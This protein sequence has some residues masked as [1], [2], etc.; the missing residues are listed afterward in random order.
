MSSF[1]TL[2]DIPGLLARDL[3]VTT[4]LQSE[5]ICAR[6]PLVATNLEV[7]ASGVTAMMGARG[8]EGARGMGEAMVRAWKMFRAAFDDDD[9]NVRYM[10]AM[11]A[12]NA[13]H[14]IDVV[15]Y[16][17]GTFDWDMHFGIHGDLMMKSVRL[18]EFDRCHHDLRDRFNAGER[19]FPV[20]SL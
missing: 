9:P 3:E 20:N 18:Y 6:S 13:T 14:F 4:L 8:T 12:Y 11:H 7:W 19:A 10:A 17:H 16:A 5:A 15:L 1:A 2:C